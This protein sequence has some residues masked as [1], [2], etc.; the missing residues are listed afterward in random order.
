MNKVSRVFLCHNR[1]DKEVVKSLALELLKRGAVR[2]WL[3]SWEIPGGKE[4]ESHLR[5]EFAASWSSLVFIGNAGFGPYQRQ[6]IEWAKERKSIDPDYRLI[7]VILPAAQERVDGEI[8]TVLPGVQWVDLRHGWADGD[9]LMPLFI[10]LTGDRPGAPALAISVAVAAE[11]WESTGRTDTSMLLRGRTL[12]QARKLDGDAVDPL[13]IAFLA[14]STE[15]QYKRSRL[16]L[17]ILSFAVALLVGL[18]AFATVQKREAEAQRDRAKVQKRLADER[19]EQA[20]QSQRRAETNYAAA[21]GTIQSL[22][23]TFVQFDI[24]R[25][26]ISSDISRPTLER[27]HESLVAVDS[28]N[29]PEL[30]PLRYRVQ[31]ALTLEYQMSSG[32]DDSLK[33]ARQC[34]ETTRSAEFARVYDPT[35]IESFWFCHHL[36]ATSL[37]LGPWRKDGFPE[38]FPDKVQVRQALRYLDDAD[39]L[40]DA[41]A[42]RHPNAPAALLAVAND[43]VKLADAL[44]GT[45]SPFIGEDD[46]GQLNRLV[47]GSY[48]KAEQLVLRI[49]DEAAWQQ[50]RSALLTGIYAGMGRYHLS[51]DQREEASKVFDRLVELRR[52]RYRATPSAETTEAYAQAQL[53]RGLSLGGLSTAERKEVRDLIDALPSQ[54]KRRDLLDTLN[55][56]PTRDGITSP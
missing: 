7:P 38:G 50:K 10:A 52:K 56:V 54:G 11:Q 43:R 51:R 9:D 13:S 41:V 42:A 55:R 31:A 12:R 5:R 47:L 18:T 2:T 19:R 32:H 39:A 27:M 24:H 30:L 48:R 1:V 17:V 46:R 6:E 53:A 21:L 3:D 15:A 33:L 35:K 40:G 37:F 22:A 8:A 25:R 36:L 4:W 44:A 49:P 20:E 28:S 26:G 45:S 34:V 16:N 14:A 29:A 23:A